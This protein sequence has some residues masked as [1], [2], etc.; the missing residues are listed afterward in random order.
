MEV[1]AVHSDIEDNHVPDKDNSGIHDVRTR[2]PGGPQKFHRS[3]DV[4]SGDIRMDTYT[5]TGKDKLPVLLEMDMDSRHVLGKGGSAN[6][7]Q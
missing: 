2:S 1:V 4:R 7:E 6:R 5:A 3:H